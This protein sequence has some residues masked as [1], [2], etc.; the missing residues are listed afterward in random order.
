MRKTQRTRRRS[1]FAAHGNAQ[2]HSKGTE[3]TTRILYI[4]KPLKTYRFVLL[5]LQQFQ[6]SFTQ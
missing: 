3:K 2:N 4:V 5:F 6:K 1:G